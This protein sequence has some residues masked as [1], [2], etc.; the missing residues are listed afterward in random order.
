M[1]V[2]VGPVYACKRLDYNLD[3]KKSIVKVCV[4]EVE[5]QLKRRLA[6]FEVGDDQTLGPTC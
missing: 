1:T 3:L 4:K 5:I 2:T 6:K